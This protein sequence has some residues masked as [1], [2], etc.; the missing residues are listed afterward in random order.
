MQKEGN[1]VW[2]RQDNIGTSRCYRSRDMPGNR[3]ATKSLRSPSE[4]PCKYR[5]A[6]SD[7]RQGNC[8]KNRLLDRVGIGLGCGYGQNLLSPASRYICGAGRLGRGPRDPGS[9]PTAPARN[10]KL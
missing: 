5:F 7:G 4:T 1:I 8:Q 9:A 6:Q 10:V 2:P 3:P